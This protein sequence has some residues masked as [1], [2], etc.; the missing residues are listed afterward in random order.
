MTGFG[1]G[2]LEGHRYS[3]LL[4]LLVA[5]LAIQTFRTGSGGGDLIFDGIATALA[6]AVFAT[7]FQ[8]TRQRPAAAALLIGILVTAWARYVLPNAF[9]RA[10]SLT[11]HTLQATFLWSAVAA[12]LHSLFVSRTAGADNVRGAICGYL[13]AG[14]AWGSVNIVAYIVSPSSYGVDP[15]VQA[16]LVDWHGRVALFSYYSFAQVLTIGYSDVTPVRAPA[17]T[18][19]LFAALFGVFYTAVVVSQLVTVAQSSNAGRPP[20]A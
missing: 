9:D 8:G 4:A 11:H 19:S 13:I 6:I 14:S 16:L 3:V 10:L 7:V 1:A 2:R 20:D 5:S 15:A 18:L 12:I 17:T